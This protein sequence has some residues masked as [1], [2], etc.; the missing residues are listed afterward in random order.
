MKNRILLIFALI[1]VVA[2]GFAQNRDNPVIPVDSALSYGQLSNGLTYYIRHNET[3][4][5]RADFYFVQRVGSIVESDSQRGLAHFLEHMAF[6]GTINF[7]GNEMIRFLE[8]NGVK[9]GENLNAYTGFDET[10]YYVSD[11]PTA[12]EAVVDS[13]LLILSDWAFGITTSEEE[14][15]K[16]RGVVKEEWRTRGNARFR[17]WEKL[18]P[19]IF[20]GSKYADRMPIGTMEVVENFPPDTLRKFYRDWY[21]PDLQAVI[22]VGDLPKDKVQDRLEGLF[23][24]AAVPDD[25]PK[26]VYAPV[27]DND[28]PI[29]SI[30][31]DKEATR[32]GINLFF[33]C[34]PVSKELRATELGAIMNY[35]REVSTLIIN[36]RLLDLSQSSKPPFIQ[37]DAGIGDF[38]VA[39]TK[40]AF[41][42]GCFSAEDGIEAAFKALVNETMRIYRHG[43]TES[44]YE[45]A[46]NKLIRVYESAYNERFD[47]ENRSF[48][49]A[50]SRHFTEG[51]YIPG[52]AYEYDLIKKI[53]ATITDR[54]SV[55]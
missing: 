43:F 55:V 30:V 15:A 20:N 52:I 51:G 46:K 49:Q 24:K 39:K 13:A 26:R 4:K 12:D 21:R 23:G 25:A 29:V 14:I 19:E 10:V 40:D 41:N 28:F 36:E 22:V 3:P 42:I 7:P 45:R 32:V 16:E 35:V 33:K 8:R 31:T 17:I 47:E 27:P 50:Y 34:D 48:A 53:A 38:V 11:L 9:F 1:L 54:K 5:N 18:F 2:Q 37:A 6:N 44:E